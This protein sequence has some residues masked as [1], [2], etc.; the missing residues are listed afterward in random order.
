MI[1]TGKTLFDTKICQEIQLLVDM[2]PLALFLP[3]TLVNPTMPL[4]FQ[5]LGGG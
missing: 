2:M 4:H 5:V 3:C 1:G